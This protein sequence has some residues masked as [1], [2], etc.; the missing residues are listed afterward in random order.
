MNRIFYPLILLICLYITYDVSAQSEW[1]LGT[2]LKVGKRPA[3]IF[4]LTED[5]WG[6]YWIVYCAGWDENNNSIMD[7]GDEAPSLWYFTI[8]NFIINSFNPWW[9]KYTLPQKLIDLDFQNVQL[10]V[11]FGK[12]NQKLYIPEPNGLSEVS[13]EIINKDN[14][15]LKAEKQTILPQKVAAISVGKSKSLHSLLYLSIRDEVEN[16]GY[17]MIYD[18]NTNEFIDTIQAYPKVQMTYSEGYNSL[19]ILNEKPN[20]SDEARLQEVRLDTINGGK[21]HL[22]LHDIE[23]FDSPVHLLRRRLNNQQIE[24]ILTCEESNSL[25][26]FDSNYDFTDKKI[27]V[28]GTGKYAKKTYS[29]YEH[30]LYT[31]LYDGNIVYINNNESIKAFGKAESIG[32]SVFFILVATPYFKNSYLPDTTIKFLSKEPVSVKDDLTSRNYNIYPNP[33]LNILELKLMVDETPEFISIY[34][35]Y[36]QKVFESLYKEQIDVSNLTAGVY[37]LRIGNKNFKFVKE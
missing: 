8:E 13:I 9:L 20:E 23:V 12:D 4:N 6:Q 21:K 17:V 11:R 36:G 1:V 25:K 15:E 2:E 30:N 32:I 19:F 34:N 3:E 35:L 26:F 28:I 16:I 7:E 33:V 24:I 14:M 10:P 31:T 27:S 18:K 22:V 37:F 29:Y 5:E